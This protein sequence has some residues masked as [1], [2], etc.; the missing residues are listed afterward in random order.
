M[1]SEVTRRLSQDYGS[2]TKIYRSDI[3]PNSKMTS[4]NL[5]ADFDSELLKIE[6]RVRGIHE[7]I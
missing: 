5:S 6:S 4:D 2:T 3:T 7:S 1:G